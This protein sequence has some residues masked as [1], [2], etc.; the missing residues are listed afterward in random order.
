MSNGNFN[1]TGRLMHH[2]D[3]EAGAM[4]L[5]DVAASRRGEPLHYGRLLTAAAGN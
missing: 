4:I 1:E 5:A 2:Y 3:N